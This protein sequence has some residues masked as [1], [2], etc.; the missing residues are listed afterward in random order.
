M[1]AARK[2]NM[3]DFQEC[4]D[5]EGQNEASISLAP[6]TMSSKRLMKITVDTDPHGIW[7]SANS[8]CEEQE[9]E[10]FLNRDQAMALA[11]YLLRFAKSQ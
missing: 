4:L 2:D 10:I 8:L 3:T 9:A 6:V 1:T 5:I 11:E 7:N